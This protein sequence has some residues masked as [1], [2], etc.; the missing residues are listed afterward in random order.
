M[1]PPWCQSRPSLFAIAAG[2]ILSGVLSA[3][4]PAGPCDPAATAETRALLANLHAH[5]GYRL[6]FGAHLTTKFK[7]ST[8]PPGTTRWSDVMAVTGEWPGLWGFQMNFAV[9]WNEGDS[10]REEIRFANS[11][12]APVVMTWHTDNPVT[13]GGSGDLNIDIASL[14]PG[15]SNHAMLI[16]KLDLAA[17]YL[18]TLTDAEGRPIPVLYRPWHEHNLKNSFWWNKATPEQFI[19]L[20]RF[21]VAHFRDTHGLHNLLY[22]FCPNYNWS[23]G[24]EDTTAV[25]LTTYPGDDWVDVLGLDSYGDISANRTADV[26]R[27]I[28]R[29]ANARGKLPTFS[30]SG[31]ALTGFSHAAARADW[32]RAVLLDPIEQDAELRTL[33]WVMTWYNKPS[34]FWVP[35][36][37]D[38]K[39][40]DSFMDFYADPYTAFSND[41]PELAGAATDTD[42]DGTADLAENLLGTDPFDPANFFHLRAVAGP[43]SAPIGQYLTWQLRIAPEISYTIETSSTPAGPWTVAEVAT[44]SEDDHWQPSANPFIGQDSSDLSLGV[45]APLAGQVRFFRARASF[46]R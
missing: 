1:K 22:V 5:R 12:G 8:P 34:E 43:S 15:G 32:Y 18:A 9:K 13:D 37:P 2:L 40:Y 30:E 36:A 27:A 28:V 33:S 23:L 11:L 31:V 35:Y 6:L 19:E 44:W 17:V 24:N 42:G 3:Q 4:P 29:L 46:A 25:Y 10:M 41:L 21:T 26:L 14:L 16:A 20:W 39:G 7:V 45:I 38:V